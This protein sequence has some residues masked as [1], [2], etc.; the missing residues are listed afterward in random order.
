MLRYKTVADIFTVTR[1]FC[2]FYLIWLAWQGNPEA[3]TI[4]A[5]ILLI[6]W[7]TDV[8]DG[9]LAR[10]GKENNLTWVGEHD[11]TADLIVGTGIWLYLW[12]ADYVSPIFGMGYLVLSVLLLLWTHAVHVAWAVQAIPYLMMIITVFVHAKAFAILLVS[13]ILLVTIVTWPRF[14]QEK[15]PEFLGGVTKL[16]KH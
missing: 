2:G 8:L 12:S 13:W 1:I 14:T 10:K 9:P 5:S 7:I 16:F 11:L 15:V 6:S 4:A 3:L